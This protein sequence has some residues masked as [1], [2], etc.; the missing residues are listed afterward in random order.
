VGGVGS[1]VDVI[2]A[3]EGAYF[4]TPPLPHRRE[5]RL[6]IV[7]KVGSAVRSVKVGDEV[8]IHCG[9]WSQDDRRSS[10]API[11][12][13]RELPHLGYETSWGSF[14]QFT[15]AAGAPCL[16]KPK[17][18]S[19]MPRPPTCWSGRP[20][21]HARRLA[22]AH[23]RPGDVVLVWAAPAASAA[24]RSDR[25]RHGRHRGRGRLSED[26]VE[27]CTRIG[28]KGCINRKKFSHWGCRRTGR[29]RSATASG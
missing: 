6:R 13:Q 7:W 11:H 18:L 22:A 1:P 9:V 16:P 20:R 2:K 5:R 15:R 25:A 29:T 24:R 27:F 4:P 23:R 28:A 10:R 19:W 14:A 3:A 12:V 8:V 26:K 17:Q 21:T